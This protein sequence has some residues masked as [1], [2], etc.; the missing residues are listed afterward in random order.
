MSGQPP[1]PAD[2]GDG[3]LIAAVNIGALV[4]VHLHRHKFAIDDLGD[5][6]AL[7]R[8]AI[9]DVT[10]MA[11]HR[12]DVEQ[13]GLVLLLRVANASSPHSCHWIGWCM[14]ERR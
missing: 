1:V 10:P 13:D 9:H 3:E 5:F 7:V 14:A 8:L 6:G 2:G 12:A 4:A 11:P